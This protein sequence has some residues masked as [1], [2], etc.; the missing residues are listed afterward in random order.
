MKKQ[1]NNAYSILN[2]G[3][4]KRH[5][6][7]ED[8]IDAL[9][10]A[11]LWGNQQGLSL[12]TDHVTHYKSKDRLD[13]PSVET[14]ELIRLAAKFVEQMS[15][16]GAARAMA[17]LTHSASVNGVVRMRGLHIRD[18][19]R[20]GWRVSSPFNRRRLMNDASG[21]FF[22]EKDLTKTGFD[23][24]EFLVRKELI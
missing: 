14:L 5:F 3:E 23:F 18:L 24:A 12:S 11:I 7:A 16:I 20:D 21:E 15:A 4:F 9:C 22:L 8:D 10:L 1:R 19:V 6:Y 13:V 17:A 2:D